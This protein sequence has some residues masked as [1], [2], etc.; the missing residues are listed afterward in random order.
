[1][2][3][4]AVNARARLGGYLSASLVAAA[5]SYVVAFA[6]VTLHEFAHGL[7]AVALGGYFPFVRFGVFGGSAVY[8][9]PAPSPAWK[10]VLVLLAGPLTSLGVALAALGLGATGVRGGRARL[11]ALLAGELASLSFVFGTGLLSLWRPGGGGGDAGRALGLLALPRVYYYLFGAVWLLLGALLAACFL[12]LVYKEL[13]GPS[14]SPKF[15]RGQ[16][17]AVTA[18]AVALAAA[19]PL[20]LGRGEAG[21]PA[22]LYLSR[23]PPE[24]SVSACNVALSIGDEYRARVRVLMRPFVDRQGH[25]WERVREAEPEDW[26]PYERFVQQ[27]LPL[28]LGTEDVR[29]VRRYADPEAEFF[30]GSWGRGARVVEAEVNLS[31][32]PFLRDSQEVRVLRVVDFWRSEGAGYIDLTKVSTEGGRRIGGFRS[33]PEGAGAPAVRSPNQLQWENTSFDHSFAVSHIA[34]R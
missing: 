33:Q 16:V 7:T 13:A 15:S 32:L 8:L 22:G 5:G 26:A 29:I 17:L 27:K 19:Q 9:F 14:P 24:V 11:L 12:R 3:E 23:R 21:R 10:E 28:M 18:A 1:V 30:N 2:E 4:A 20:L 25:L 34:I 31:G 6:L